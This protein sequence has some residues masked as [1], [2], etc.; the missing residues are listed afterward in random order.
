MAGTSNVNNTFPI[1]DNVL[2]QIWDERGDLQTQYP[3]VAHDKLDGLKEWAIKY[4]WKEDQR[5]YALRPEN[6]S[7]VTLPSP[8]LKPNY[9]EMIGE[10]IVGSIIGIAVALIKIVRPKMRNV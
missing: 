2:Y 1:P 3:E 4:G 8:V 7:S 9:D 6:Q 10:L 5:L